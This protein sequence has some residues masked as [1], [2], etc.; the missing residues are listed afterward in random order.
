MEFVGI[1]K[2]SLVDYDGK[3]SCVLFAEK[4]NFRC[5]FCHNATLVCGDVQIALPFQDILTYL[6]KRR[7]AID[8]VVISGGEP[9]LMPDLVERISQIKAMGFLV[10]LD[11][12]GSHPEIIKELIDLN[13]VDYVA[14]DIKN[15]FAK[16]SFTIGTNLDLSKI[17]E[18]IAL[19]M[20]SSIDY[21]FRTTLVNEFHDSFSIQMM[22]KEIAGARKVFLQKFV[23][24]GTCI[25]SG[26]HEVNIKTA[27]EFVE[28]LKQSVNQVFL[29]GY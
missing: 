13:L 4:C 27:Q 16:Y 6:K 10:K 15:S 23:D 12:N 24:R 3:V 29:R 25:Q 5:P 11:T 8:A 28:I 9:T 18:S 17:K 26:L 7:N 1:E 14:M 20:T 21:E 19:L 22:A 2:F